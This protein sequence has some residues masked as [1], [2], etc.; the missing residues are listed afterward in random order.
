MPG[1]YPRLV[2]ILTALSLAG[3]SSGRR[4]GPP[5]IPNPAALYARPANERTIPAGHVVWLRTLDPIMA[6]TEVRDRSFSALIVRDVLDSG[7]EVLIPNGAPVR[8]VVLRSAGSG[9]AL[10][11]HSVRIYGNTYL[12]RPAKGGDWRP[13]MPLGVLTDATAGTGMAP[14][15]E[16][17]VEGPAIRVP[18][19]SLLLYRL[20]GPALLQ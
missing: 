7:G 12:I 18:G 9:L 15:P 11:M 3:C 14:V 20:G 1:A 6:D 10:G 8:L 4:H 19:N 5:P 16:V 13:G 2:L 17:V